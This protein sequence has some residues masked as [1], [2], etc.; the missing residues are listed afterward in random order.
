MARLA[1]DKN[2]SAESQGAASKLLLLI[3][4]EGTL[5]SPLTKPASK[6][7]A[8]KTGIEDC[9][10]MLLPRSTGL[11]FALRSL[12]ADIDDLKLVDYTIGYPGVPSPGRAQEFFTLRSTFMQ[13]VSP[14]AVHLHFT[15]L[16]LN[17][18]APGAPPLGKLPETAALA[19]KEE[20]TPEER[21]RF[22]AWL[23]SRWREKDDRMSKF[24]EVGDFLNGTYR[25][26]SQEKHPNQPPFLE[27]PIRLMHRKEFADVF[28]CGYIIVI[29]WV[30]FKAFY[31]IKGIIW[32]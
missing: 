10:N 11:L 2:T 14:P 4:P 22:D 12:A 7:Y 13:G 25:S 9:R 15:I 21:E 19:A 30:F 26:Q 28:C 31:A 29:A 18:S 24:Y 27:V 8:E 6:R 32:G 5:V 16:S 23:L 20:S 17:P 1:S 3:F